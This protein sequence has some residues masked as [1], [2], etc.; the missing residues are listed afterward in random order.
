MTSLLR[1]LAPLYNKLHAAAKA[2]LL[3][4]PAEALATI[5]RP[6]PPAFKYDALRHAAG[7]AGWESF[8][9][10]GFRVVSALPPDPRLEQLTS[11]ALAA[12]GPEGDEED[13]APP[14]AAEPRLAAAEQEAADEPGEGE[15]AGKAAAPEAGA[16]A[17]GEAGAAPDVAP[18]SEAA[19]AEEEVEAPDVGADADVAAGDVATASREAALPGPPDAGDAA[20]AAAEPAAFVLGEA[21]D[22]VPPAAAPTPTATSNGADGGGFAVSFDGAEAAEAAE[23]APAAAPAVAGGDAFAA[24]DLSA[25][26]A[27]LPRA[28]TP[29]AAAAAPAA[30]AAKGGGGTPDAAWT[31]F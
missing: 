30:K 15:E 9:D 31:S 29:K 13:P 27:V 7:A 26:S 10:E 19:A 22:A 3:P 6:P 24:F 11:P 14:G 4:L 21:N 2:A 5:A 23:V 12:L 25:L 16:A 18:M 28:A 17:A 8:Q 20:E 1:R